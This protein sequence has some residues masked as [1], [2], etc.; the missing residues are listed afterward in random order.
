MKNY[1][2]N[3]TV[4][5]IKELDNQINLICPICLSKNLLQICNRRFKFFLFGIDSDITNSTYD[6]NIIA[7]LLISDS[8]IQKNLS[9]IINLNKNYTFMP[10]EKHKT[11]QNQFNSKFNLVKNNKKN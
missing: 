8:N 11:N 1:D 9:K 4:I 6:Y 2:V 5:E 10:E 3:L 7:T